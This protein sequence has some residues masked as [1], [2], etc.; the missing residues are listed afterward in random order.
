MGIVYYDPRRLKSEDE[1]LYGLTY[2]PLDELV[3]ASYIISIHTPLS[4]ETRSMFNESRF[5]LMKENSIFIN[6]SRGEIVDEKAL[7]KL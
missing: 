5:N 6:S 7:I 1:K 3:K 4:K 2:L